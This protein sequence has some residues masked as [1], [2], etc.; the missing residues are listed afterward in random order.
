MSSQADVRDREDRL[1]VELTDLAMGL[2][3]DLAGRAQKAEALE[4]AER[5]TLAFDRMSRSVRLSI[6]LRRRLERDDVREET[7]RRA[8]VVDLRKAKLRAKLRTEIRESDVSFRIRCE[9]ERELDEH[10][11]EDALYE[12]FLDLPF[13]DAISKLR[14][15]LGLTVPPPIPPPLG[16]ADEVRGAGSQSDPVGEGDREAVEGV[17]AQPDRHSLQ[18]PH[19]LTAGTPPEGEQLVASGLRPAPS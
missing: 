1:L 15:D 17:A 9:L 8:E 11:A 14:K 13:E 16:V 19:R 4:D 12:R 2:A 10:L 6:A 18:P 3:R 7:V 5:F